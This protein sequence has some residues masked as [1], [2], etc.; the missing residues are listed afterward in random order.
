MVAKN[1]LDR[2]DHPDSAVMYDAGNVRQFEADAA[3]RQRV[4]P[5]TE[6]PKQIDATVALKTCGKKYDAIGNKRTN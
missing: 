3:K 6:A 1:M 2:F 5:R 4:E